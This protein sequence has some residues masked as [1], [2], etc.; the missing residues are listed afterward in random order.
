[1]RGRKLSG[2]V[3]YAAVAEYIPK[4]DMAEWRRSWQEGGEHSNS[5][6]VTDRCIDPSISIFNWQNSGSCLKS[7]YTVN[8]NAEKSH[9]ITEWLSHSLMLPG[10]REFKK[11]PRNFSEC[12]AHVAAAPLIDVILDDEMAQDS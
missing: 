12:V 6:M 8:K 10:W 1:M 2:C 5:V 11:L 9:Y 4:R 3:L 7:V